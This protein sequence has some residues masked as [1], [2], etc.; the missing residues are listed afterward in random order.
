[1]QYSWCIGR[2]KAASFAAIK[3][4]L[5][6]GTVR[7]G[8][9]KQMTG[10]MAAPIVIGE[11]SFICVVVVIFNLSERRLYLHETFITE[12]IPEIAASSLVRGSRAA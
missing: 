9:K 12:R 10:M 4:V 5:E 3:D 1:M 11:D 7:N 6:K 8:G 2:I